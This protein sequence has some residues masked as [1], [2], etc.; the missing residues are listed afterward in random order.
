M[1]YDTY[2]TPRSLKYLQL[3]SSAVVSAQEIQFKPLA[4]A[5]QRNDEEGGQ[6][7]KDTGAVTF[8]ELGAFIAPAFC[9]VVANTSMTAVD[10]LFIGRHSSLEL[11]ALGPAA[12]AFDGCSFLLTFLNTATLSLLG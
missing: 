11:A 6:E 1:H 8:Q 9:L 2:S 12:T 5:S 7:K 3:Q 4:E 10:K